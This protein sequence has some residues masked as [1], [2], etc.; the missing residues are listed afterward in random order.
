MKLSF[1]RAKITYSIDPPVVC[2]SLY[3]G[4]ASST[5]YFNKLSYEFMIVICIQQTI[6]E[7]RVDISIFVGVYTIGSSASSSFLKS[8]LKSNSYYH[9]VL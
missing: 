4:T 1:F 8:W 5:I 3:I 9:R 6:N 2:G 7:K